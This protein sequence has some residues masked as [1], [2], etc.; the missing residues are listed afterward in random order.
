[1]SESPPRSE[2]SQTTR[3]AWLVVLAAAVVAVV[4]RLAHLGWLISADPLL[5]TPMVDAEAYH[6]WALEI[7][8]DPVG[9]SV[10][11]QSPGYPYAVALLYLIFGPSWE[12]VGGLQAL[13]AGAE[14]LLI[15]SIARHIVSERQQPVAMAAGAW[16]MALYQPLIFYS[17]LL[18]KVEAT[19]FITLLA[20][21]LFLRGLKHD[22]RGAWGWM[23]ASGFAMGVL[24][25]FRGNFYLCIPLLLAWIPFQWWWRRRSGEAVAPRWAV[26]GSAAA[27]VVGLMIVVAA[28][29]AR[30]KAVADQWVFS[31][32][33]SGAVMYIG[34]NP[35][36][37]LGDYTHMPFVRTNP[38]YEEIDVRAEAE[39]RLGR[40]LTTQEAS[41]Y[42]RQEAIR[43][44]LDEPFTT[45]QRLF[46]KTRLIV[47]SYELGDNYSLTFHGRFSPIVGPW[48]P[49]W[50]LVL[51]L[52]CAW[53]V[54]ASGLRLRAG[55]LLL[56]LGGY[57][58]SLLIFFV[59]SRY[60]IPMAPLMIIL[61]G[62]EIALVV[63]LRRSEQGARAFT[64]HL[65]AA[66]VA[67]GVSLTFGV[68]RLQEERM[69]NW[70]MALGV[71][72]AE[73]GNL[74]RARDLLQEAA[75]VEPD[76]PIIWMN[77]GRVE[78]GQDRFKEAAAHCQR[79]VELG[80][81][82]D[83]AREC[84]ALARFRLGDPDAAWQALQPAVTPNMTTDRFQLAVL[85]LKTRG[86]TEQALQLLREGLEFRDQ[87]PGLH[88]MM[89]VLLRDDRPDEARQHLTRALALTSDPHRRAD[90]QGM[91]DSLSP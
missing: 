91:I 50:G 23:T 48:F 49:W 35:N 16:I 58:A 52:S 64:L 34:N 13:L 62:A 86:Q 45:L 41:R 36:S 4:L 8:R 38:I 65:G 19:N 40:K 28:V 1:M 90:I 83:D 7:M 76:D 66:L 12:V 31:S 24:G 5:L 2:L 63:D 54:G 44:S 56:L 67:L 78:L 37:P 70:W 26:A 57:A 6:R 80:A 61:A 43:Y 79:S 22:E 3:R 14:V 87:E 30:N 33:G 68:P 9:D 15:A 82:R 20:L 74:D 75:R 32:A 21:E 25:L 53:L 11:F 77:Y 42:W 88:I 72:H 81:N 51:A 71:A 27:F 18:L 55:P 17:A 69:G 60:R 47:E 10:F 46:H 29:T 39:R 85:I 84:L 73:Q 59:R 89:A